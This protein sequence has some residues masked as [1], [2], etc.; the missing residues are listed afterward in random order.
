MKNIKKYILQQDRYESFQEHVFPVTFD[1]LGD[2]NCQFSAIA[3]QMDRLDNHRSAS[4]VMEEIVTYLE[5]NQNNQQNML[6][7]IFLG[8]SFSQHLQDLGARRNYGD[9]LTLRTAS[10]IYSVGIALVSSLGRK[11]QLEINPTELQ[12]FGIILLGHF[13]EGHGDPEWQENENGLSTSSSNEEVK[14]N[15]DLN[16][17]KSNGHSSY[18][19]PFMT[20]LHDD[21]NF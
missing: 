4:Q 5:E 3:H 12:S 20:E 19:S 6:L 21:C 10:N 11:G 17:F 1:Q 7:K 13:A 9:E 8:I 16:F 18:T 14:T 15:V 2:G